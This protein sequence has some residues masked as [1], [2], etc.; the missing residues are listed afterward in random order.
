MLLI[1]PA[2]AA[3]ERI[4]QSVGAG[5]LEPVNDRT[6]RVVDTAAGIPPL[7]LDAGES[8]ANEL[9]H[10]QTR[11]SRA[12]AIRAIQSDDTGDG[13]IVVG[14]QTFVVGRVAGIKFTA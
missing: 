7:A 13:R 12:G 8:L 4:R 14:G 5:A 11:E 3:L 1:T 10:A 9:A 2:E 6:F